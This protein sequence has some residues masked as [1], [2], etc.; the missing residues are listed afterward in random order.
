MASRNSSRVR[1]ANGATGATPAAAQ[2]YRAFLP[3]M[4]RRRRGV[5]VA[6]LSVAARRVFSGWSAYAASKWGLLGLVES[7]R[8][9]LAGSGVRVLA[10]TPGATD[11]RLWEGVPGD[12]Q[13]SRMIPVEDVAE[14]LRWGLAERAGS[15][16]E[17]IRI[18][19]RG[20]NL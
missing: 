14:A 12:W 16:I 18:Q 19:P 11:T 8:E 4:L 9:E 2:L 13:R 17:E 3:P 5:L 6:M 1:S 15:V 10:I 20:G 7:L